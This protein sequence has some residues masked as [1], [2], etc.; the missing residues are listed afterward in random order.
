MKIACL[1]GGPASLYFAISMKRRDPSHDITIFERNKPDDTFGW[2]VVL[3]DETLD[4]MAEND[5]ESAEAIREH[6]AYWDD[7]AVVHDGHRTVST[8]HG[9]CGVGRMQL[10]LTLQERARELGVKMEFETEIDSAS[11]LM[12]E[13]DLVV[14]SD[15]L[16]SKTRTEFA[17]HFKPQ[18]DVRK[19]HFVWL[20]THQKFDDAFTFIFEKT[21]HGW[22]WAHAYQFDK[23][24]ATFIVECAPETFEKFG[25]GEISQQETIAICEEI[26]KDHLGGHSLMTNAN[27]IRGSAWLQFPRVLCEKWH[28]EN[29]VLLGDASAT[30][31]F[32][33]GSGTKLAIESAIALAEFLHTEPTLDA[34]FRKYQED[35]RLD[36]LRL[37]SAARNS[38]EWFEDVERYLDLDPVQ[39]NYSLLTRS[40]RISHENLRLRDPEWLKSAE[41]WFQEQAGA[42][43]VHRA[44]MFAPFKLRD[45]E[46]KNRV[47]VSPMAQYKAKDGCPTD[48]HFAHYA[49]RAK[50]G[51]GLVYVEMTCVSPEGRIT[52]GCPG[53]YAPE[54]EAAWTRLTDFVHS[55]TS[56]KM[57]MQ[58]GHSG[59]KGSTQLGW[60]T[61]D[62]PI[63][64]GNWPL[65]SASD[66]PWS[67]D[68]ATPKAMDRDDM[69][70]VRDQF[71]ASTKMADRAGFDM[72]EL[73]AAHGYLISSFISPKSNNRQDEYGGS[74][75]NRMRYPLEVAQAM[76]AAWPDHKPMSVRISAND[77]VGA[78]GVT[79]DEAVKIAQMFSAVGIDIIDVSAGQTSIDAAPIYG[80]MFQTPFSDRIRNETGLN[81]MA[82]GNIYEPDHINSI[83]M[84]GRADLVCLARPHLADPYWTLH[85]AAALGDKDSEW[86]LPYLPGRDQMMRLA[87]RNEGIGIKV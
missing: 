49:E 1:G 15:G 82:V 69:D 6:F 25:F 28:H 86:P 85:A 48:W 10:L 16:N 45:M 22:I 47:V 46:L 24:T 60:E 52:P 78:E 17:D 20:G 76:R 68:N 50:G 31:H 79:P 8:G 80:R 72:V 55:E 11:P 83:L 35:R 62:A 27:H 9:F 87:E 75:E 3:S 44:P 42:K 67:P 4:N 66:I 18:I 32:S 51:A 63:K 77:W 30:A 84:A 14:A 34:A 37:Q 81:T 5:K 7:I 57:A 33:I 43:G 74:L 61:M 71:V 36:V 58:I 54:H 23:D 26:F 64:E 2:G 56:A 59:R 70:K 39:F 19:C 12:K 29:V 73:H 40:Q 53:L 65:L 41:M 13:Y 38:T 21:E